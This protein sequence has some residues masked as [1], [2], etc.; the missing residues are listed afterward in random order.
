MPLILYTESIPQFPGD[1]TLNFV[2]YKFFCNPLQTI[3]VWFARPSHSV[4]F[5]F[6]FPPVLP[7][8]YID[9]MI[10]FQKQNRKQDYYDQI[11]V[12]IK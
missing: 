3:Y 2:F 10:L 6:I 7:Y 8:I 5:V 11:Y 4:M 12:K 9:I 1:N